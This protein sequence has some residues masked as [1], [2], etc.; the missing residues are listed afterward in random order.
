MKLNELKLDVDYF[1]FDEKLYHKLKPSPLT[2]PKLISFNAQACDL[3][4]LDYS[5]CDTQNFVNFIKGSNL[6]DGCLPYS[7]VYAGH[8]FGYFVPQLGDGRAINLGAINN[9]HLQTKGSGLT[10]Y[11]RSGDGRAV[12]RSSI[13]EYLMSEAMYSLGIPTTRALAIIDSDT[14]A[15]REWEEESCS[16]V[17]RMSPSWVRIGTFEFFARTQNSKENVT[18]LANYVIKQSYPHLENEENKYEKMFYSLVDKSA[19]LLAKWQTYGF[20]HGVMNTDNFSMAG[21]TI[22]Y[23]PYAFMDYFEKNCICNHTDAEGRY[24]YNNQPYVARWNL[25]VLADALSEICNKEKLLEYMKTFLPQHEIVYLELM[26]KRLGLD[27]SKSGNSNLSLFLELL[28]SLEASK[29]DYNVFFYRLTNIKSFDD[30]SSILDIAVFQ[31]PLKKWFDSYKKVCDE[32]N[33][34]FEN[35]YEIMKKVNPKYILKN[36]IL[37]EAIDK[38][39]EGDYTL[40]NDLLHIAQNPFDEHPDF[41]RYAQPTPMKFANIKLSCSS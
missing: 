15:N 8:Q 18:Q 20:Q 40:V 28:G 17:M 22:D 33:S 35:R 10:R 30:L 4:G 39:H 7:M 11:S 3:I 41:D 29:M 16:I 37:Q 5:E 26:N 2:N 14:F 13:R 36:Y 23:G 9:W 34:T 25:I 6:L 38:A 1:Q 31:D 19:E 21:V 12:L 32:E 24:S 27:I